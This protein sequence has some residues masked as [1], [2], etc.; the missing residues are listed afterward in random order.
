[1]PIPESS[2]NTL[3]VAGRVLQVVQVMERITNTITNRPELHVPPM[4][5]NT[6]PVIG[7]NSVEHFAGLHTSKVLGEPDAWSLQ[8]VERKAAVVEHGDPGWQRLRPASTEDKDT[9][10]VYKAGKCITLPEL[11][12][13]GGAWL[14]LSKCNEC[15]ARAPVTYCAMHR[16]ATC[17]LCCH[18]KFSPV[19][20]AVSCVYSIVVEDYS[21]PEVDSPQVALQHTCQLLIIATWSTW[22]YGL[23]LLQAKPKPSELGHCDGHMWLPC[24]SKGVFYC[25][26]CSRCVCPSHASHHQAKDHNL[27]GM[28][29][30][31]EG[32][33]SIWKQFSFSESGIELKLLSSLQNNLYAVNPWR[34]RP[35]IPK[36][37]T[38]LPAYC[39]GVVEHDKKEET[40]PMTEEAFAA[41]VNEMC[42][43]YTHWPYGKM[44]V[45]ELLNFQRWAA[46]GKQATTSSSTPQFKEAVLI[47][48]SIEWHMFDPDEGMLDSVLKQARKMM[49]GERGG[50]VGA[51]TNDTVV[52]PVSKAMSSEEA[53][54]RYTD[55][56]ERQE[57]AMITKLKESGVELLLANFEEQLTTTTPKQVKFWFW[58]P[59]YDTSG[60]IAEWRQD[61]IRK[62][63]DKNSA[64]GSVLMVFGGYMQFQF[65]VQT[66]DKRPASQKVWW[67]EK[68]LFTV[69]RSWPRCKGPHNDLCLRSVTEHAMFFVCK[70]PLEGSKEQKIPDD[71]RLWNQTEDMFHDRLATYRQCNVFPNYQPPFKSQR[72]K[73]DKGE[74]IRK[75]VE[76][77]M[78]MCSKKDDLVV[79]MQAGSAVVG[80]AAYKHNRRYIGYE[81]DPAV[82]RAATRRLARYA[83]VVNHGVVK[84]HLPGIPRSVAVGISGAVLPLPRS[85]VPPEQA[86]RTVLPE[87][88]YNFGD[89]LP[90][91]T[92][93]TPF[94][95]YDRTL[96]DAFVI[97]ASN[98]PG[99]G[100]E[101][102][103]EGVFLKHNVTESI[104]AGTGLPIFAWG[105]VMFTSE[106]EE[107]SPAK[108]RFP[109]A[110]ALQP[111]YRHMAVALDQRC[112][113]CKI[114]DSRGTKWEPNIEFVQHVNPRALLCSSVF[115]S[116]VLL[117]AKSVVEIKP[118]DQ[119]FVSYGEGYSPPCVGISGQMPRE[120]A[121][122][123]LRLCL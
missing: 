110:F 96:N 98:V 72:P 3:A 99:V 1:M 79:D 90:E 105:E 33:K 48:R 31:K 61:S 29:D 107:M 86:G 100:R 18:S 25:S 66:M 4:Y 50:P 117:Q 116:Q 123:H 76:K 77:G 102:I 32:W 111:P 82:H 9:S 52:Q 68:H 71:A 7:W 118:G 78:L 24:K 83:D 119:L 22:E 55:Q 81:S 63:L 15:N 39:Q 104:A 27:L 115:A 58:D 11:V 23:R 38:S 42:N 59:W 53:D 20:I 54:R 64:R 35:T 121:A 14:R 40:Y 2:L 112:P 17:V 51:S 108:L 97:I 62:F 37:R 91:D 56:V 47:M 10:E 85:T 41:G 101:A 36:W 89:F 26:T 92:P 45:A 93:V 69:V 113:A 5:S 75:Q 8:E 67:R 65:W 49:G 74:C 70:G 13:W 28:T 46:T 106:F 94:L 88:Q 43:R 30:I 12:Q 80:M 6:W 103:G 16:V 44:H 114:N 21:I 34:P 73:N 120:N 122:W 84:R 109:G 87:P 95:G 19:C 60:D 57:Q